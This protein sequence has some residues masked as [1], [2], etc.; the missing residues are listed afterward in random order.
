M[1][2]LL[3]TIAVIF[4]INATCFAGTT[5]KH[6]STYYFVDY[7]MT[8]NGAEATRSIVLPGRRIFPSIYDLQMIIMYNEQTNAIPFIRSFYKFKNRKQ[9]LKFFSKVI[10]NGQIA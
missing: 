5:G 10:R 6:D 3:M 2:K 4:A 8:N 1:K 9:Y 7:V